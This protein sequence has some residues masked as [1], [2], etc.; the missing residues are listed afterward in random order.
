LRRGGAF[1]LDLKGTSRAASGKLFDTGH[2]ANDLAVTADGTVFASDPEG[3]AVIRLGRDGS[4]R[5]LGAG[6]GL[7]SP[8]GLALSADGRLLYVADWSNGLAAIDLTSGALSW[9]RAPLGSTALG[10]DGLIR[11]GDSL[12]AIQNGV[13]PLRITRFRLS[14]GG[15]ALASAEILE[16]AVPDWDEPT[17]GVIVDGTLWYVAASQ[18]PRY[19]EDGKPAADLAG[20]PPPH[21]RR[22]RLR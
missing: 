4:V 21:V 8:G 19:S 9:L 2:S 15:A 17:L 1:A 22:L 6:A 11:D 3:K 12:L 20:L 10:I 7:R 5:E 16:R 13:Y 18:W 14:P